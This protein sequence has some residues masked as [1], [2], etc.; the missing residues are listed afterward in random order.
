V[1]FLPGSTLKNLQ[2]VNCGKTDG[3]EEKDFGK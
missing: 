3:A 2:G 1:V